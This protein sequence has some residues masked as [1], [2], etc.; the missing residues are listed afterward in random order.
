MSETKKLLLTALPVTPQQKQALEALGYDI[1]ICPDNQPVPADIAA[2][3]QVIVCFRLFGS[4]R[5]ERFSKAA[6]CAVRGDG[7]GGAASEGACRNRHPGG[8][9]QKPLQHPHGRVDCLPPAGSIIRKAAILQRCSE[10]TSGRRRAGSTIR[11]IWRSFLAKR[12]ASA[13][14]GDIALALCRLLRGFE[15]SSIV[16]M[17]SDGRPVEG[18][19]AC[20]APQTSSATWSKT[21]TSWC[22]WPL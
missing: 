2:Q 6:L 13:A 3:A 4:K 20:F 16:G 14:R 5:P 18:Y 17:N 21:A 15:V 11:A 22:R 9:G 8:K 1:D 12:W 19:D 10:S 7:G